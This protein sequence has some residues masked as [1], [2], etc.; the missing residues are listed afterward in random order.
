L[1]PRLLILN[2]GSSS[3]KFAVYE[4]APGDLKLRLRGQIA[5]IGAQARAEAK[6]ASGKPLPFASADAATHDAALVQLLAWLTQT[7]DGGALA[8]AGHRVVHGGT[9]LTVHCRVTPE[10]VEQLAALAPLAP[11]HQPHNIAAIRALAA[12]MPDLPQV[13]CFDTAFHATQPP[14]AR[15]LALPRA[16][17]DKGI[18]RYGFHGLSY[19]YVVEKLRDIGGG[20]VPARLVVAHLGNGASMCALRDGRSIATTMGFSTLDGLVMGTRVGALDPGVILHLMRAEG[21]DPPEIED[22][23]YNKSGLLGL[24][25]VSSDMK[26]LLASADPRAAEAVTHY[27]Y[28]IGRELGSLTA[29][30]GGLDGL[31]FTGGIGENATSV[32]AAVCRGAAWL[33]LDL[34]DAANTGGGPVISTAESRIAAWVLATDEERVIARHTRRLLEL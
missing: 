11:H 4:T 27:C 12:R 5:G 24:S 26:T 13:A 20:A 28:R 3:L 14:Q 2:A 21:M 16:F 15:R 7:G 30:L 10:I 6:D 29:A 18:Q 17:A 31:V 33:G 22:L 34:D 1:T 8:G 19:E 25:G 32:R 23:L 9:T